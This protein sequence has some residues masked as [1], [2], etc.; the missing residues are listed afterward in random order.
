MQV[1]ANV[2]KVIVGDNYNNVYLVTGAERAAFFDS[3]FDDDEH[4]QSVLELWES[5]GKPDVAAIVVSHRHGDHSGGARKISEATGAEVFS[6]AVEKTPI[7]D[8]QPGIKISHTPDD[9]ETLDLGGLTLEF[10]HTPGHTVGS[11]SALLRQQKMLF[12]GDTIRT[13]EPFK[14]D[15]NAG[16]LGLHVESL[17]KLQGYE[18]RTIGPGHGPEVEDPAAFIANDLATLAPQVGT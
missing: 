16:D 5:V 4:V 12:A 14:W 13:S 18:L 10:V 6:S 7:E 3:G 1:I 8:G 2:H 15:P 9:G 17:R 11:L